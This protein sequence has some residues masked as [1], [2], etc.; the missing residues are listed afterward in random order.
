MKV[1]NNYQPGKIESVDQKETISIA[2]AVYNSDS[3]L[4]RAIN[5]LLSQ[6]YQ[7]L[8]IILVDDGSTDQCPQICD[9][10][11]KM[12]SRVKVI[13]KSNGGLFSSRNVGIENATG[14][15]IAF[16][17]GDDWVDSNMYESMLYALQDN[18][19]DLVSCRY[20]CIFK[21]SII[22][23]STNMMAIMDNQEMLE[24]Y[25]EEDETYLIQN[26]AWNKLYKRSLINELRFPERWYEDM[27]FTIKLLSL[28]KKSVYLDHAYHNYVCDRESSIMNRGINK[29][30]FTD[31]IPN[32]YDRSTF[33]RS[34][35]R[36]DLALLQDYYLYKRLLIFYIQV[37]KSKDLN[38]KQYRK[39]LT[40]KLREGKKYYKDM[41]TTSLAGRYD[42]TKMKIFLFSPFLYR[43]FTKI[44]DDVVIPYK[45]NRKE[46]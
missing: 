34:I 40:N 36:N 32:L 45:L 6:T 16:L 29:R 9:R 38:R 15:Y 20:R 22:D 5:S 7:N 24:K 25:L 37:S 14:T 46:T 17:D 19:A 13:H 33:L 28:P 35:D 3:Y 4:E 31:L 2:V 41:Y 44:N 1:I 8:E 27:L 21:D 18:N 12:D 26:A 39:F 10:F 11:A 23:K 30:I 43:I 42:Y